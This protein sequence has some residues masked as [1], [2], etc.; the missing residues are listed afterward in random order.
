MGRIADGHSDYV[1]G[2]EKNNIEFKLY[3][4]EMAILEKDLQEAMDLIIQAVEKSSGIRRGSGIAPFVRD[5]LIRVMDP[6][7]EGNWS[8]GYMDM[9]GVPIQMREL[10]VKKATDAFFT[11]IEALRNRFLE[12]N[13]AMGG[14]P[15]CM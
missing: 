2:L 15:D 1:R 4:K 5:M 10:M 8:M 9:S 7:T 14:R 11:E 13:A 3:Q 6:Y 12:T